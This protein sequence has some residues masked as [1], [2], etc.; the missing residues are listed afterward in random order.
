[1]TSG[2]LIK[3][4]ERPHWADLIHFLSTLSGRGLQ[5]TGGAGGG[6]EQGKLNASNN[7]ENKQKSGSDQEQ[8][9]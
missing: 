3:E 9:H 2:T 1:M 8:R 6:G 4:A 5:T 7:K